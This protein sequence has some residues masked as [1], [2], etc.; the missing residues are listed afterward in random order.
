MKSIVKANLAFLLP[1]A[2]FLLFGTVLMAVETKA[3]IHLYINNFHDLFFDHFFTLVTNLGE[4]PIVVLVFI[5]LLTVKYR[6]AVIVAVSNIISALFT[7]LLKH[8]LFADVVRPKKFFQGVHD[9]YFVPGVENWENNSF[10][11]GHTTCAFALYFSLALIVKNR[12]YKLLLFFLALLVGYSRVYLSQHFFQDVYAGSIV[13]VV[14]TCI[15]Y[16]FFQR[17][18]Y[19]TLDRSLISLFR[20]E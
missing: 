20:N 8:T 18:E 16:W 5:I 11:S 4:G 15:I 2:V 12:F 3:E 6:Y 9:L 7:Q 17:R 19:P 14:V 13:G 10:P 1:Y